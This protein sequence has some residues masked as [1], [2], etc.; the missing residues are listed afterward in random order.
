[1]SV[2]SHI[3]PDAYNNLQILYYILVAA[4]VAFRKVEWLRNTCLA[5]VLILPAISA[6]QGI[7][8]AS[9]HVN[10]QLPEPSRLSR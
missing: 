5:A 4:C 2:F 6:I 7:V 10:G 1:M 9:L 3:V 8:L